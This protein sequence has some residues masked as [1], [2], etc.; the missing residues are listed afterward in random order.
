MFY[1]AA[2]LHFRPPP[3]FKAHNEKLYEW[4]KNVGPT[5]AGMIKKVVV[6]VIA[7]GKTGLPHAAY[8]QFAMPLIK[9][10]VKREAIVFQYP[11]EQ[12]PFAIDWS[13]E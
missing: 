2:R 8:A 9:L 10:G 7:V 12:K 5:N 4:L 3:S 1:G 11:L 6:E 13:E